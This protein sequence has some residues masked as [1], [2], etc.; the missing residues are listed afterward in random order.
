[1]IKI[2]AGSYLN[3]ADKF[4]INMGLA[5]IFHVFEVYIFAR[6]SRVKP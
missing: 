4:F 1:M 6:H 2:S 3:G 5:R